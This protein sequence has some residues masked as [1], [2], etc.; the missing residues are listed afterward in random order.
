LF[1]GGIFGGSLNY[2]VEGKGS[3]KLLYCRFENNFADT[4]LNTP[5]PATTCNFSIILIG[6]IN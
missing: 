3:S 1:D 5:G 2:A 4:Y 6:H